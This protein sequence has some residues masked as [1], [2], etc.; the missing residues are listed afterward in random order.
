MLAQM[1]DV[2]GKVRRR[3]AEQLWVWLKL[4]DS[5]VEQ[6]NCAALEQIRNMTNSTMQFTKYSHIDSFN[7]AVYAQASP[8]A[9]TQSALVLV[10]TPQTK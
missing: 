3:Y 9:M 10:A 6:D 1:L 2:L 4:C 8:Q 7:S 5:M